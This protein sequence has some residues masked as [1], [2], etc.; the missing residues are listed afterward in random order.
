[1]IPMRLA[2]SAAALLAASVAAAAQPMTVRYGMSIAGLP[3]GSATMVMTPNGQSTEVRI[4]GSAGGPLEIGRMNASAVV[5]PGRVTAQS[6]SGSGKSATSASLASQGSGANS[7][8][9]FSGTSSRGPGKLAMTVAGGRVTALDA[10][11]PDNP[12]AVR[13][14]LTE[15]HKTGV[16][17]PMAALGQIIRPGGTM[18]PEGLC[19]R[20]HNV[21]T[22][23]TRVTLS[24]SAA[25][26]RGAV[27]G[28]P[29]G[30][31]TVACRVTVTPV[32]GHRIDKGNRPQTRTA[33]VVFAVNGEA[34]VLWSV[35]VPMM[36]G[37]FTLTANEI[38]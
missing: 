8:F 20:T 32:A 29:E 31:G 28:M 17:D 38:R 27:R 2:L 37:S 22:G 30:Y 14:P 11:I 7:A 1:M 26:Q 19:G 12:T 10:Q 16:V 25:E 4:A 23:V 9:N 21:F 13:V 33:S 5:A 35:S 15:A 24:G 36:F 3:I 34:A 6:Q 18:R